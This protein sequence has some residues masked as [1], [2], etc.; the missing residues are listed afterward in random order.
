MRSLPVDM[1]AAQATRPATKMTVVMLNRLAIFCVRYEICVYICSVLLVGQQWWWQCRWCWWWSWLAMIASWWCWCWWWWCCW[2]D[3][4]DAPS[5]IVA[6]IVHVECSF[7]SFVCRRSIWYVCETR[8]HRLHTFHT[9]TH[10]QQAMWWS[11]QQ[12]T[13]TSKTKHDTE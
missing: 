6:A 8:S 5:L 4:N 7:C 9:H 1:P 12:P 2:C 10:T 13:H 11:P 3:D